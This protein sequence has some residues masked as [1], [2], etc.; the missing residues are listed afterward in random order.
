MSYSGGG[1]SPTVNVYSVE[2]I[3]ALTNLAYKHDL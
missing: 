1:S 3:K 2:T